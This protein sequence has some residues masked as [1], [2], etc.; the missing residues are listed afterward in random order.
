MRASDIYEGSIG[1]ET[2]AYYA[3]L[4]ERGVIGYVAM[5]LFRAQK[6]SA[7]AKAYRGGFKG[8]AYDRKNW[9]MGNLAHALVLNGA[10]LGIPFGWKQDPAQ[11]FH[12]WVLYVDL[13][14][15]QVSF[16]SA[17]RGEGPDYAGEWDGNHESA[18]RICAFCDLVMGLE[19]HGAGGPVVICGEAARP[20]LSRHVSVCALAILIPS[21]LPGRPADDLR[22]Q[23]RRDRDGIHHTRCRL[24]VLV[25]VPGQ[26]SGVPRQWMLGRI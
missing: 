23:A 18:A 19:P 3:Q 21:H 15:G 26:C 20:P 9:S 22:R 1:D 8:E 2:K 16:H 13:P 11:A 17:T 25:R 24:R 6:C 7:R 4:Q 12:N 10:T 5:N 14:A